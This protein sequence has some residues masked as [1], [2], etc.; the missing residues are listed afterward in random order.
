MH[1]RFEIDYQARWGQ[2]MCVLGQSYMSVWNEQFPLLMHCDDGSHWWAEAEV[3][4]FEDE[5]SYHYALRREDGSFLHEGGPRRKMKLQPGTSLKIEDYWQTDTPEDVF[6]RSGFTRNLFDRHWQDLPHRGAIVPASGLKQHL[7]LQL[8]HPRLEPHQ[9]LGILGSHPL[10]GHWQA[11]EIY[12]MDDSLYPLWQAKIACEDLAAGLEATD[13]GIEIKYKYVIYEP[14]SRRIVD[15]ENG[16][17]RRLW[18]PADWLKGASARPDNILRHDFP[19]RF[20]QPAWRGAGTAI[21]LFSLRSRRDMGI[22]EFPDLKLL[23]DWAVQ[24]GQRIIQTLPVNDTTLHHNRRDSYPYNAVSVFALNPIF[25]NIETMGRLDDDEM[26]QYREECRLLNQG[27]IADYDQVAKIKMR[28]FQLI[29]D[30]I[31]STYDRNFDEFIERNRHWI[32]DYAAFCYLRDR[33]GTPDFRQWPDYSRY[34]A[35]Q[36]ARLEKKAYP[37]IKFYCFLQY[38]ADRQLREARHY[39]R[40]RGVMLKGDIPI[41]ISPDSVDAWVHPELFNLEASAGAPPDDFSISGQ[42]WG[43]PTYRWDE[44]AK[45][46]F[47]W[48]QQRFQKMADYFDAYRIDH[49]LGFFRIWE[50][51]RDDV[52]GLRGRFSPALPYSLEDLQQLGI[53]LGLERLVQ[54]YI[55]PDALKELFGKRADEVKE[56]FL[57]ERSLSLARQIA[58]GATLP[59]GKLP[60]YRFKP[61]FDTQHKVKAWL[62][63]QPQATEEALRDGLYLLLSDVLFVG[64]LHEKDLLHP[65]ISMSRSY[66]FKMLPEAMQ[67]KLSALYEDFFYHR[68]NEFWKASALQKLPALVGATDMLVCGEDLGM[69]PACVPEVMQQLNILSLEI[70]R[71]PKQMREFGDTTSLPWLSVCTTGTHDMNP[72]RAW[73]EEDPEKTQRY[74]N[75]VLGKEGEAPKT[76]TAAIVG[77][78]VRRH[79][80]SP[81]MWVILPWQDW[82]ATEAR[83]QRP[84][85]ACERINVPTDSHN[86]WCYRMH[87]CLEDLLQEKTFNER[88]RDMIHQSG[89]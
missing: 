50:N 2:E 24:T 25:I 84:D 29:Y 82:I 13:Q 27:E 23:A 11:A 40:R 79:L 52:W 48:W 86:Y 81:A 15:L 89:R 80:A 63:K 88:L 44:M 14:D 46:G 26:R 62:A 51:S 16:D 20:S 9:H 45:D 74:Y 73:W 43:F 76:C 33:Y 85:P 47:R 58:G 3:S 67:R 54:P 17:D 18:L 35:E 68:H 32:I 22:G 28:W 53:D 19:F 55:C 83:L 6:L 59:A 77:E 75:Q 4:D 1:L 78:I 38:H 42:N 87:L 34:D 71:M 36:V 66:S 64:D 41:G 8:L 30:R 21:P 5:L 7:C 31:S 70:Q 57:E 39:A 69:V 61:A 72:L 65:R 12:P 10:L 37:T 60:R 49:I 56:T